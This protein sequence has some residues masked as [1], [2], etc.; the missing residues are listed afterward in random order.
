MFGK[1]HKPQPGGAAPHPHH[2]T[3]AERAGHSAHSGHQSKLHGDLSI[4][5]GADGRVI[6][7]HQPHGDTEFGAIAMQ[8]A[9]PR[10]RAARRGFHGDPES[11]LELDAGDPDDDS[12]SE[13]NYGSG[14]TG[15]EFNPDIVMGGMD[16]FANVVQPG[17]PRDYDG[18]IEVAHALDE[19]TDDLPQAYQPAGRDYYDPPERVPTLRNP[20]IDFGF[21]HEFYSGFGPAAI[22]GCEIG[23]ANPSKL[24]G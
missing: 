17:D 24:K 18:H 2:P 11:D 10:K 9:P 16:P 15:E 19:F 23:C 6:I 3:H 7:T 20:V 22:V 21:E 1:R 8:A 12:S 14:D 4:T 5:H 13:P